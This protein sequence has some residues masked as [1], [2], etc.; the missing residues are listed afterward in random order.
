M[1]GFA[2]DGIR[3]RLKPLLQESPAFVGA[4]LAATKV[5]PSPDAQPAAYPQGPPQP[6]LLE[7]PL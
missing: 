1:D 3:S 6:P 7:F 4:A 2:S 5:Y